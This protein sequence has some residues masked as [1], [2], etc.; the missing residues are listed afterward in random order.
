MLVS[1]HLYCTSILVV[2]FT[3]W[4]IPFA[5]PML[6]CSRIFC[7]VPSLLI[8]LPL[9]FP[10]CFVLASLSPFLLT[11]VVMPFVFSAL[12]FPPSL[13]IEQVPNV[14]LT[15]HVYCPRACSGLVGAIVFSHTGYY[16]ATA[17]T[18]DTTYLWQTDYP[19]PLIMFA[20][21]HEGVLCV[22]C[23]LCFVTLAFLTLHAY[24]VYLSCTHELEPC[25]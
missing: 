23:V 17:V 22:M 3:G 10:T 1:L 16:F 4:C 6:Y 25:L 9:F 14:T 2:I 8:L 19:R 13:D 5:A 7:F 12:S 15:W 20:G 21:H 11:S 24:A 18:G